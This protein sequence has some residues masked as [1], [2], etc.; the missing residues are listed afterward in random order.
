ME[1]LTI[2]LVLSHAGLRKKIE[3][4]KISFTTCR[5]VAR[6]ASRV[7][8]LQ[9]A[10]RKI[11]N[12]FGRVKNIKLLLLN[13]SKRIEKTAS[14]STNNPCRE[15]RKKFRRKAMVS[16]KIRE[17][18]FL[19]SPW[20]IFSPNAAFIFLGQQRFRYGLDHGKRAFV[21]L[22]APKNGQRW[23]LH[24]SHDF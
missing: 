21:A 18:K 19:I 15:I 22:K 6:G 24:E 10:S 23:I 3:I 12:G 4:H 17:W 13:R 2:T 8:Q 20:Q 5:A 1:W 14:L 9:S 11:Q 16:A 7:C